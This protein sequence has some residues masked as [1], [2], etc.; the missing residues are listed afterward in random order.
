MI[1]FCFSEIL[2]G[3][4]LSKRIRKRTR[5]RERKKRKVNQK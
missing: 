4:G 3:F 5:K 1:L 2:M